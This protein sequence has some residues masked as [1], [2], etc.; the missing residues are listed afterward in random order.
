MSQR[1]PLHTGAVCAACFATLVACVAVWV[2]AF[3]PLRLPRPTGPNRVGTIALSVGDEKPVTVQFWYPARDEPGARRAPYLLAS[4]P[5]A[6]LRAT[7]SRALV[8]T[9]SVE[10]ANVAPGKHPVLLYVPSWGGRRG[11]NTAQAQELASH[12]F[13]VAAVD[14]AY[15]QPPL[16][17]SSAAYDRT[18]RWCDEKVRL[19]AGIV[20]RVIDALD[21]ID[22]G[23]PATLLRGSLDLRR[24]G[25]FGF[26]FGGAVAAEVAR[27]DPRVR[28]AADL[29]GWLFGDA[30]ALGVAQPFLVMSSDNVPGG[31]GTG[32][33][34]RNTNAFDR[35]NQLQINAGLRRHGGYG[36]TIA[37]SDHFNFNDVALLPSIRRR[38]V[39]PIAGPRGERII[40]AYLVQFFDRHLRGKAAPLFDNNENLDS[41]AE[42]TAWPAP[43]RSEA[44]RLAQK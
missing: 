8:G 27:L 2:L 14:D 23:Q 12:G 28:A 34:A 6:D 11:D 3:P 44:S 38:G 18:L 19:E 30:A 21:E 9:D 39:G 7:I 29:D 42:L 17:L 15:P 43:P 1:R 5:T 37:G 20:R 22:R 4:H 35:A 41:A 40:S 24:I 26:S 10:G 16:D 25:T 31:D 13:I 36:L 32:D 33:V